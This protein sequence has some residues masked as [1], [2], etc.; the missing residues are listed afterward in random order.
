VGGAGQRRGWGEKDLVR[1]VS[2]NRKGVRARTMLKTKSAGGGKQKKPRIS[3]KRNGKVSPS[4]E[5]KGGRGGKRGTRGHALRLSNRKKQPEQQKR[6]KARQGRSIT[7]VF[8]EGGSQ[9]QREGSLLM[10]KA[11]VA[12]KAVRPA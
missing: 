6:G 9:P 5:D 1:R 8:M 2:G 3:S 11:R 12:T 10:H 4:F 7:T